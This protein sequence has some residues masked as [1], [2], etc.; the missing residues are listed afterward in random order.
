MLSCTASC[1]KVKS[2]HIMQFN[3]LANELLIQIIAMASL[4]RVCSSRLKTLR[5]LSIVSRRLHQ[6]T[7]P[8]LY[9]QI[10]EAHRPNR[11]SY[12]IRTLL[13]FNFD[14]ATYVKELVCDGVSSRETLQ[15]LRKRLDQIRVMM[16]A[17]NADICG[18]RQLVGIVPAK[19]WDSLV[20]FALA[21]F[22]NLESLQIR[23]CKITKAAKITSALQNAA[24][25]QIQNDKSSYDLAALKQI[26]VNYLE[27][28]EGTSP[29]SMSFF[30]YL[31]LQS[32][33]K[34]EINRLIQIDWNYMKIRFSAKQLKVTH[35][36]LNDGNLVRFLGCFTKLEHLHIYIAYPSS[37]TVREPRHFSL[38]ISHLALCLKG[39]SMGKLCDSKGSI[40]TILD[41]MQQFSQMKGIAGPSNMVMKALPQVETTSLTQQEHQ[42]FRQWLHLMPPSVEFIRLTGIKPTDPT[43]ESRVEQ[44]VF[45]KDAHVPK[46]RRIEL[47]ETIP[48]YWQLRNQLKEVDVDLFTRKSHRT[49]SEAMGTWSY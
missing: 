28:H 2:T 15:I 1:A 42:P 19:D 46:L 26:H 34:I 41:P 40:T 43:I 32:V 25:R 49:F 14:K 44:V 45:H 39:L 7:E 27:A 23:V 6:L 12:F 20:A 48:E 17:A 4:D 29:P 8:F 24:K 22:P 47:D 31:N 36:H 38:A 9:A 16:K 3:K 11:L 10:S 35:C 18:E 37:T 21:S 13:D 5:S 33:E 30:P